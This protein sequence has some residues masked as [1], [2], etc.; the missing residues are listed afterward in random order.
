[1]ATTNLLSHTIHNDGRTIEKVRLEKTGRGDVATLVVAVRTSND[2]S[3]W[4]AWETITLGSETS[5]SNSGTYVQVRLT[6]DVG[7]TLYSSNEAGESVPIEIAITET[8]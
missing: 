1:M 7:E 6:A 4:N 8:S 3:N 2:E 5:L